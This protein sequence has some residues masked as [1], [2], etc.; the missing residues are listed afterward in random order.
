MSKTES[1]TDFNVAIKDHGTTTEMMTQYGMRYPDG[2]VKWGTETESGQTVQ[3]AWIENP[4]NNHTFVWNGWLADR[5][6]KARVDEK[7]YRAQHQRLKRTVIV[8]ITEA[9]EV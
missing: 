3:F 6:K 1:T 5:A 9:E 4:G 8:A 2:T 7:E